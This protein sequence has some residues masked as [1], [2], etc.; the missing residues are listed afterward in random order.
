MKPIRVSI[1]MDLNDQFSMKIFGGNEP[2]SVY[3]EGT[4]NDCVY[5]VLLSAIYQSILSLQENG[6]SLPFA[7]HLN[8]R[9]MVDKQRISDL[10]IKDLIAEKIAP[11]SKTKKDF[12]KETLD[13]LE[14]YGWHGKCGG[15]A[16]AWKDFREI[17]K[18]E[19][20]DFTEIVKEMLP[21]NSPLYE[22]LK[23][24]FDTG[25]SNVKQ[26]VRYHYLCELIA[27]ISY[28]VA[29]GYYSTESEKMMIAH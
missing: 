15:P 2:I 8:S 3:A 28:V 26:G 24:D 16:W 25:L 1:T 6:R 21:F 20:S 14:K 11:N 27:S 22:K 7:D 13:I 4:E 12:V 23:T 19:Y 10:L 29:S 17:P 9:E 5:T 18:E